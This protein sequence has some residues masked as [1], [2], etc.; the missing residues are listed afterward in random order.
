M[1]FTNFE[2]KAKLDDHQLA[3]LQS[4]FEKRK[5]SKIFGYLLIIFFGTVGVHRIYTKNYWQA[6]FMLITFGGLSVWTIVDGIFFYWKKID[7]M[8]EE[9]EAEIIQKILDMDPKHQVEDEAIDVEIK[10][11]K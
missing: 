3:V 5:K 4:E 1:D 9:I 6:F 10:D 2:L 7:R 8:N 11:N